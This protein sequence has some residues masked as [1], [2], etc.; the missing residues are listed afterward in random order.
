MALG[1]TISGDQAA[2]RDDQI[3]YTATI[4]GLLAGQTAVYAWSADHGSFVGA[5]DESTATWEADIAGD[6]EV[7]VT[8]SCDV[9]VA[10]VPNPTVA[11]GSLTAMTDLGITGQV[12]NMYINPT[13]DPG[14]SGT[15][16]IYDETSGVSTLAAGSDDD[17]TADLHI[18]RIRLNANIGFFIL[19]NNGTGNLYDYFLDN[20]TKSVFLIF[21]DGQVEELTP[22]DFGNAGFSRWVLSGLIREKIEDLDTTNM[23]LVGV[24]D[25]DSIGLDADDADA[26]LTVTV[27][28]A[29]ATMNTVSAISGDNQTGTVGKALDD[30]FVVEVQDENGDAVSGATVTFAV[31]AGGGTLSATSV[32]SDANGRAETIL[33]LGSTAGTN[34]VSANVPGGTV[35]EFTATGEATVATTLVE[36]SGDGQTGGVGTALADPFVVE[37]RDQDGDA[38]S[39]VTVTF[40]VTGGGGTLSDTSVTTGSNGQAE[41]TLTL[42]STV[43]T[44]TVTASVSGITGSITFTATAEALVA[45][46]LVRISGHNQT[47]TVGKELDDPFVVEVRDQN[48]DAFEG[49]TVAFSVTTGGGTLSVTS[50]TSEANG[51]AETTFTLG[52]TAGVNRARA[53]VSGITQTRNFSATGEAA[54]A[55]TVV[56]IS[57]DG[58]TD[59]AGATL[60]DPFVVEVRDQDGDALSGVA[61]A[62]AVTAGGGR[63]SAAS[64]T[65]NTSGRAESTLTLGSTAGT[66][67]VTATVSGI[68]AITFTAAVAVPLS[69][70]VTVPA[71]ADTGETVDIEATVAG[72]D[73]IE[74]K[75]TGGSIDDPSATDTEI[76]VPDTSTVIAVTGVATDAGGA[77]VSDTAYLTVGDPKANIYTPAVRIEI[78]G[79]DVTDRWI[80]RDGMIVGKQLDYPNTSRFRSSEIRFNVDNEDGYFDYSNPNNFFLANGLPAHGRGAKVLVRL[81]LSAS[82]LAPVFG[83][84]ISELVTSLGDTKAQITLHDLSQK[85]SRTDVKSFGE[86]ITRHNHRLRR[87]ERRL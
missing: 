63:L 52:T 23:L 47:G 74:W 33:T 46:T 30:P 48:G 15:T 76:T 11:S 3:I 19:N 77:T 62:F 31:T 13:D 39:G 24:A 65:T 38:L 73:T 14:S 82:E 37:V 87:R 25:A 1:V 36:I 81:G 10:A 40:A 68:T 29:M 67:T 32:T 4:T 61:V 5:V 26:T 78:E 17:L 55:T 59:D 22:V 69:I 18:W 2:D 45:T 57:G 79:V 80:R 86:E 54:V 60:D 64:V 50:V 72:E 85:L 84:I 34:T 27:A 56:E 51:R 16:N 83:G 21:D 66:N 6:E 42:G 9:S 7:S 12:L 49:T 53:S 20:G 41:S 75:T 58:Q 44:N 8:I 70:S 43:G 71:S 28:A 35:V